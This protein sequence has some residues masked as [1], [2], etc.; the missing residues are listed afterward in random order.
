MEMVAWEQVEYYR[1]QSKLYFISTH[2]SP[3]LCMEHI[4][5]LLGNSH[6]FNPYICLFYW[7]KLGVGHQ[8]PLQAVLLSCLDTQVSPAMVWLILTGQVVHWE[9]IALLQHPR[10]KSQ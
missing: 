2:L 8:D 1:K 7:R 5:S 4:S 9:I 10:E 6:T 3:V